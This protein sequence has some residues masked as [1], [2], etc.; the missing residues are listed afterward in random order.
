[1]CP[2]RFLTGFLVGI[3][4][5]G[6]SAA[7]QEEKTP[8]QA[9]PPPPQEKPGPKEVS[10]P[11]QDLPPIHDVPDDQPPA[12]RGPDLEVEL[13]LGGWW[14]GKFDATIQA[15]RRQIDSSLLVDA[16]MNLGLDFDGWTL[17]LA[18]DYGAGK[19]LQ[20]IVGSL[21]VGGRWTLT[22]STSPVSL[23]LSAGPIVGK[24]EAEVPAF[25]GFQSAVGFEGRADLVCQVQ[26]TIGIGFWFS[27]RQISFKFDEP[28]LSG[29]KRAGGS[30]VAAGIGVL[31]RF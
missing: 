3:L 17:S 13:R 2:E 31:M 30:G 29:D 21:L 5:L 26:E 19:D 16:G 7:A 4:I 22:E 25:G 12:W 18:G 10:K 15:G 20:V 27:Y 11:G 14:I 6:T 9:S 1:M 23:G 24:L 28:V 8:P